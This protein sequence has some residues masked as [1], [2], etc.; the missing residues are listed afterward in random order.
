VKRFVKYAFANHILT[1]HP[2]R[3]GG[4]PPPSA[5]RRL[6]ARWIRRAGFD[7]L[8]MG[9]FWMDVYGAP[10]ALLRT[11]RAECEGEDLP[12]VALNCLRQAVTPAARAEQNRRNLRRALEVA[13]LLGAPMVNISLATPHALIGQTRDDNRG[14]TVSVGGSR[15]AAPG[16][17]DEVAAFL[18]DLADR[19]APAGLHLTVELHHNAITDTGASLARLVRA[20]D[21]P[22]VGGNPD[23]GNLLWAY[24]VPEEPYEEALL[25]VL[26][27]GMNF[28]HVKNVQRVLMP[29]L[30]RAA[31]VHAALPEGDID[32]RWCLMTARAHGYDGWISIEGA[33]PGD[34]L[35]FA[36]RGLAYLRRIEADLA[37]LT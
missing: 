33:G 11:I 3:R 1:W 24:A 15:G 7:G 22:N 14:T 32:Y 5:Q 12:I 10:D 23:L 17:E 2:H 26:D 29:E 8:E 36:E 37:D 18:R 21:R 31:F 20:I 35:A 13:D 30:S 28:W 9:D 4:D 25:A 16:E 6:Q 27:A 34:V 19:A